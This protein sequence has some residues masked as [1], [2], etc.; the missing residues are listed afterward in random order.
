MTY[1]F[2]AWEGPPPLSNAHASSECQRLL[3]GRTHQPPTPA[4]VDLV[5]SLIARYPDLDQPD[6]D[7]SPWADGPLL[8]LADGPLL[9]FGCRPDR[10]D[11]VRSLLD[12]VDA[13][14]VVVF[15]PQ[16]SELVPS[17]TAVAR[18]ADFE[19]PPADDLPLHLTAV[20]GEALRAEVPVAGV[21]EQVE[22]QFYV[23]WLARDGGLTIEAQGEALLP[24]EHQLSSEGR[25]QMMSLGFVEDDPNWSLHWPDGIANLDQA[26]QILGHVLI[27]IRRLP[28][29][30]PMKLQT[31]PV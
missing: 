10:A 31:F 30:T 8:N 26:G 5:D 25:D 18:S 15:D 17:A 22:T 29:G 27:A 11:E 13:D 9:Y 1:A 21:V 2:A 6:G 14:G 23:Q 16:A 28:V 12:E 7:G 3:A 4:I 24:P 20:I 19:L